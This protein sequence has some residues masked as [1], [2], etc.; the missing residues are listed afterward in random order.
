MSPTLNQAQYTLFASTH[1]NPF[2]FV[3]GNILVVVPISHNNFKSNNHNHMT[4]GMFI[5]SIQLG[6]QEFLF[7]I[8]GRTYDTFD[9]KN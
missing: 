4:T 3:V 6:K 8:N 1:I 7:S 9:L 5:E 2:I